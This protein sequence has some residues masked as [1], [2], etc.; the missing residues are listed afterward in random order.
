MLVQTL[1]KPKIR[2]HHPKNNPAPTYESKCEICGKPYAETHEI[3]FGQ[4][5]QLSIKHGLQTLLCPEHHRGKY[6]PH[7]NR[8]RDLELKQKGQQWFERFYS[9]E[10]F[11]KVF[12]RNYL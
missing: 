8:S 2:K 1:A 9:R 3:F 11:I 12:G 10:E 6:G 7:N 4:Y 5:R